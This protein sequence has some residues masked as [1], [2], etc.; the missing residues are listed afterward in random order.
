MQAVIKSRI[1][2]K[3]FVQPSWIEQNKDTIVFVLVMVGG[4]ISLFIPTGVQV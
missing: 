4:V 2:R 3:I 1:T